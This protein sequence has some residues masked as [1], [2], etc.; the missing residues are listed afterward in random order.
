MGYLDSSGNL[1]SNPENPNPD[2]RPPRLGFR[3][4]GLGF[5]VWGLGFRVK[6]LGLGFGVYGFTDQALGIRA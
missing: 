6:V 4:W 5:R 2:L 3:V 1:K